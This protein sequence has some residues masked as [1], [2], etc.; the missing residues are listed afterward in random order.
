MLF[1]SILPSPVLGIFLPLLAMGG[2]QPSRSP[3]LTD[4]SLAGELL[5]IPIQS[6]QS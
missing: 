1:A 2:R 5:P 3:A 6:A 4:G